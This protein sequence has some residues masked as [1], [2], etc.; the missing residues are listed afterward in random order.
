MNPSVKTICLSSSMRFKA[1]IEHA[2]KEFNN[3]G[4]TALFPNLEV[5][6]SPRDVQSQRRLF[7]EHFAA[8]EAAQLLYVLNKNGYIGN[9]VKIEIGYALGKGKAVI[10]SEDASEFE[11]NALA[12]ATVPLE[13]KQKLNNYL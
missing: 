3:L 10:F 5:T 4:I 7:A 12:T 9:S 1:E 2:I 6:E 11:L 8:I 13:N